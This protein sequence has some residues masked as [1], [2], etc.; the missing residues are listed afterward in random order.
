MLT[1]GGGYQKIKIWVFFKKVEKKGG[2]WITIQKI[3]TKIFF[4]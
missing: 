4:I 2:R 3:F 1:S